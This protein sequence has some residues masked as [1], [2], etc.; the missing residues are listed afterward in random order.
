MW[1]PRRAG[2]YLAHFLKDVLHETE[3]KVKTFPSE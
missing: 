1:S 2:T 3:T